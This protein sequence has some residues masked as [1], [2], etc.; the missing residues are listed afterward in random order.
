M[1]EYLTNR[2]KDV[3]WGI[4]FSMLTILYGFGMGGVFGAMEDDLKGYL[5]SEGKAALEVQYK[6]NEATMNKVV[7]KSWSY[8]KRS[9]LHGGGIGAAT[10]AI[11]AVLALT[12]SSA[13]IRNILSAMMGV[14][15]LGYSVFWLLAGMTAP[16]LGGTGAAKEALSWLAVP[17]SAMILLGVIGSIILV[18]KTVFSSKGEQV[19]NKEAVVS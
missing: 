15:G 4:L 1:K 2:L 3:K 16:G 19:E 12:A 13:L 9:H 11:I 5:K 18:A 7:S 6:G 14:G 17:S 8:F 10:L